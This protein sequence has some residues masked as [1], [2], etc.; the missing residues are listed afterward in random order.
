MAKN[1][2]NVMPTQ[3][4]NKPRTGLEGEQIIDPLVGVKQT[5]RKKIEQKVGVQRLKEQE[6]WYESMKAS[7]YEDAFPPLPDD[8][9]KIVDRYGVV[10]HEATNTA[11]Q[12]EA[13]DKL[14]QKFLD[15][16]T[17]LK[18]IGID[19]QRFKDAGVDPALFP[20]W[21]DKSASQFYTETTNNLVRLST[22]IE[23]LTNIMAQ[24]DYLKHNK[25]PYRQSEY[26]AALEQYNSKLKEFKDGVKLQDQFE[27]VYK[28]TLPTNKEF[29]EDVKSLYALKNNG[30]EEASEQ[31]AK[32]EMSL[33][34]LQNKD[35]IINEQFGG[36]RNAFMQWFQENSTKPEWRRTSPLT[37][38]K[39]RGVD[40]MLQLGDKEREYINMFESP[41]GFIG[42]TGKRL[43]V[44][45]YDGFMSM[46][47]GWSDL[48]GL[49]KGDWKYDSIKS[50]K[51]NYDIENS[52]LDPQIISSALSLLETTNQN[53]FENWGS[54]FFYETSE[55][56]GQMLPFMVSL[57]MTGAMSK[58]GVLSEMTQDLATKFGGAALVKKLFTGDA[59]KLML[60]TY[61]ASSVA[62]I[63]QTMPNYLKPEMDRLAKDKDA[64]WLDY[65]LPFTESLIKSSLEGASET[66]GAHFLGAFTQKFLSKYLFG[67]F[68]L[69]TKPFVKRATTFM[70]GDNIGEV[71]E[72]R[73]N[74]IPDLVQFAFG[75]DYV[76]QDGET[77]DNI[78]DLA[79]DKL[80]QSGTEYLSF[81][82]SSGMQATFL[83]VGS[84]LEWNQNRILE[85]FV[86]NV[87]EKYGLSTE[88]AKQWF[89]ML[90]QNEFVNSK[91]VEERFAKTYRDVFDDTAR[92][93][94]EV[95]ENIQDKEQFIQAQT[96]E[97]LNP[98]NY[99]ITGKSKVIDVISLK[100][101]IDAMLPDSKFTLDNLRGMSQEQLQ[102]VVDDVNN[103]VSK[104]N[105]VLNKIR[106]TV[107]ASTP[108]EE[109]YDQVK[110]L[111]HQLHDDVRSVVDTQQADF[112]Y[113]FDKDGTKMDMNV[114]LYEIGQKTIDPG[115]KQLA[116][117]LAFRIQG[118]TMNFLSDD[119]M[120]KNAKGI[121]IAGSHAFDI[122]SKKHEIFIHTGRNASLMEKTI[123]EEVVHR[124][125][126]QEIVENT[127]G[128]FTKSVENLF[129]TAVKGM[130]KPQ[131][132]QY[133]GNQSQHLH[134]LSEFVAKAFKDT[135]FQAELAKIPYQSSGK[136]VWTQFVK[137][138]YDLL[139]SMGI[140]FGSNSVLAELFTTTTEFIENTSPVKME[141]AMQNA[142]A[143]EA[144]QNIIRAEQEFRATQESVGETE[145][146]LNKLNNDITAEVQNKA[147]VDITPEDVSETFFT[148][149][150]KL[151]KASLS[152]DT[153]GLPPE[154]RTTDKLYD[155][156]N[157]FKIDGMPDFQRFELFDKAFQK[158]FPALHA[159]AQTVEVKSNR[160]YLEE[161]FAQVTNWKPHA[162]ATINMTFGDRGL[163]T[164]KTT[165]KVSGRDSNVYEGVT[166]KSRSTLYR[167]QT[168]D[169][170]AEAL[171]RLGIDANIVEAKVFTKY[172]LGKAGTT[173]VQSTEKATQ[174]MSDGD[175]IPTA[176]FKREL[177]TEGFVSL[178]IMPGTG[179]HL[180]LDLRQGIRVGNVTY[181]FNPKEFANWYLPMNSTFR[182]Y[183]ILNQKNVGGIRYKQELNRR[184]SKNLYGPAF[185]DTPHGLVYKD[186]LMYFTEI[187]KQNPGSTN[188]SDNLYD[189][190]GYAFS[191]EYLQAHGITPTTLQRS[192][193]VGGQLVKEPLQENGQIL[194]PTIGNYLLH[195]D[196]LSEAYKSGLA[197]GVLNSVILDLVHSYIYNRVFMSNVLPSAPNHLTMYKRIVNIIGGE[198]K[199][200]LSRAVVQ[201]LGN[202]TP[203]N[204]LWLNGNQLQVRSVVMQS[205]SVPSEYKEMFGG[206]D[207]ADG[208]S[209]VLPEV[210]DAFNDIN[211]VQASERGAA[212]KP[213]NYNNIEGR[214]NLH[215]K[216][217]FIV[218]PGS[219]LERYMRDNAIGELNMDTALKINNSTKTL[220]TWKEILQR[221]TPTP[222]QM[223][224]HDLMS[225]AH[226][227]NKGKIKS[228]TG[229]IGGAFMATGLAAELTN[230][231]IDVFQEWFLEDVSALKKTIN[232]IVNSPDFVDNVRKAA[233]TSS[234][235]TS[236]TKYISS[237]LSRDF[238]YLA[239]LP[240][241]A[242]FIAQGELTRLLFGAA[243]HRKKGSH[244]VLYPDL[245]PLTGF[246]NIVKN[247][248]PE[249]FSEHGFVSTNYAI[250]DYYTA[251]KRNLK[252]GDK[253]IATANPPSG[254][255]DI[256]ALTVGAIMPKEMGS[257]VIIGNSAQWQGMSGK[258]FDIDAIPV[259][260]VTTETEQK[261]W[262]IVKRVDGD[263]RV[264]EMT[265][266]FKNIY[267]ARQYFIMFNPE[268]FP[269]SNIDADTNALLDLFYRPDLTPEQKEQKRLLENSTTIIHIKPENAPLIELF[270]PNLAFKKLSLHKSEELNNL[271]KLAS[272]AM[273]GRVYNIK[274]FYSLFKEMEK[275]HK[276][277]NIFVTMNT[278]VD[279]NNRRSQYI[280][281]IVAR[282]D[283][284]R[285]VNAG[286]FSTP[287]RHK[288]LIAQ[289]LR[290]ESSE[291]YTVRAQQ[292]HDEIS[293]VLNRLTH[294][295]LDWA[296]NLEI[297]Q[298]MTG[299]GIDENVLFAK[300]YDGA[301]PEVIRA[302]MRETFMP[303]RK[304]MQKVDSEEAF[305]STTYVTDLQDAQEV[306][307][308]SPFRDTI[309]FRSIVDLADINISKIV[310][311]TDQYEEINSQ[312]AKEFIGEDISTPQGYTNAENIWKSMSAPLKKA[313]RLAT[314]YHQLSGNSDQ[315]TL[316]DELANLSPKQ[317]L[318]FIVRIFD[319]GAY[320]INK[321]D[322]K[323]W[324][325]SDS[326]GR[327]SII[328]GLV[329]EF[330]GQTPIFSYFTYDSSRTGEK[331]VKEEGYSG[332][333]T[334]ST[335][336]ALP[337]GSMTIGDKI[338]A[339]LTRPTTPNSPSLAR[340]LFAESISI[341]D[342]SRLKTMSQNRMEE[343][344]NNLLTSEHF[345]S[346]T[347]ENKILFCASLFGW[348]TPNVNL[349]I[350]QP[351]KRKDTLI[352][353]QT[354]Y[355]K[356]PIAPAYYLNQ[357][358]S[359]PVVL[360][361]L[362]QY[363]L[364]ANTIVKNVIEQE[365]DNE[366]VNPDG[367]VF[368][369]VLFPI[370]TY[371]LKKAGKKFRKWWK[372]VA[373]N[374][375][376]S[377][378]QIV[379]KI[380]TNT[381]YANLF[382]PEQ[383]MMYWN[384]THR[385][386]PITVDE[387]A[388]EHK[389]EYVEM[390]ME[391][392]VQAKIVQNKFLK[393][394]TP[395][396][397]DIQKEM[398]TV[399]NE[400]MTKVGKSEPWLFS[401]MMSRKLPTKALIDIY[402]HKNKLFRSGDIVAEYIVDGRTHSVYAFEVGLHFDYVGGRVDR[403]ISLSGAM[404]K[405][406]I[407]TQVDRHFANQEDEFKQTVDG[408]IDAMVG[409][410]TGLTN[411]D[412]LNVFSDLGSWTRSFDIAEG[413]DKTF[414]L[415]GIKVNKTGVIEYNGIEY[416]V[417]I[418]KEDAVNYNATKDNSLI[419][420][421][422][423]KHQYDYAK[424]M[425]LAKAILMSRQMY[426]EQPANVVDKYLQEIALRETM[427]ALVYRYVYDG[428]LHAKLLTQRNDFAKM[429]TIAASMSTAN[430]IKLVATTKIKEAMD[431]VDILLQEMSA[432]KQDFVKARATGKGAKFYMPH[433]H[434]N[435]EAVEKQLVIKY[436][437][438]FK[439][440]KKSFTQKDVDK[441]VRAEL[442]KHIKQM[443]FLAGS[444]TQ[445]TPRIDLPGYMKT[446]MATDATINGLNASFRS[447]TLGIY[448][449]ITRNLMDDESTFM[450]HMS[451]RMSAIVQ[452]S[453]NFAE[454]T[455][456]EKLSVGQFVTFITPRLG[457]DFITGDQ[458][459][460][461]GADNI[462]EWHTTSG[463]IVEASDNSFK[464][465]MISA[466][467]P[468]GF[469]FAVFDKRHTRD[470]RV[471]KGVNV[472]KK[473][474]FLWYKI[475]RSS[476]K[477]AMVNED[478]TEL[479]TFKLKA[480]G[481]A[482]LSG[483]PTYAMTNLFGGHIQNW[484]YFGKKD[485]KRHKNEFLKLLD[486]VESGTL[487]TSDE[488]LRKY[489][490]IIIDNATAFLG[491][492]NSVMG[493]FGGVITSVKA[494]QHQT[495]EFVQYTEKLQKQKNDYEDKL[496][497]AIKEYR[498][499]NKPDPTLIKNV[500]QI[501]QRFNNWWSEWHLYNFPGGLF[502]RSGFLK[503]AEW[504][505]P[506]ETEKHLR[507]R[508]AVT[509][510][511]VMQE[512]FDQSVL[513]T[514]DTAKKRLMLGM[515]DHA[516]GS[517]QYYYNPGL[518][519][520]SLAST[521]VGRNYS[522]YDHYS[523]S[524][525]IQY[526][527]R[528][529]NSL[530]QIKDFGFVNSVVLPVIR[531]FKKGDKMIYVARIKLAGHGAYTDIELPSY[532][533]ATRFMRMTAFAWVTWLFK[534]AKYAFMK[535]LKWGTFG[536]VS[537]LLMFFVGDRL[538][539]S[540]QLGIVESFMNYIMHLLS[541]YMQFPEGD[542]DD[543]TW[544]EQ[545]TKDFLRHMTT[546]TEDQHA[547]KILEKDEYISYE[548]I[549]NSYERELLN[550]LAL[551]MYPTGV[552]ESQL[553]EIGASMLLTSFAPD[554]VREIVWNQSKTYM[555]LI[556]STLELS[557]L[558]DRDVFKYF[559]ID[560]IGYDPVQSARMLNARLNQEYAEL[561]KK[562][563]IKR[564]QVEEE[565]FKALEE[566]RKQRKIA[567]YETVKQFYKN[568]P[569]N[570]QLENLYHELGEDVTKLR[571]KVPTY[572]E[573]EK[574]EMFKTGDHD[575][576]FMADPKGFFVRMMEKEFGVKV[577][578]MDQQLSDT[579]KQIMH[580]MYNASKDKD[581]F[582][583]MMMAAAIHAP[584]EFETILPASPFKT[585][586]LRKLREAG[587]KY[588]EGSEQKHT[589]F[590][591]IS[592]MF[593]EEK[594]VE[595]FGNKY[596][597]FIQL[598]STNQKDTIK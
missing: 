508:T 316:L 558:F 371:L 580:D 591:D 482:L 35:K 66:A 449:H 380:L 145:T 233:E 553:I 38:K 460:I 385:D 157:Q 48:M 305:T 184:N 45:A 475:F 583:E 32:T 459:Y 105:A 555:P 1:E 164:E 384:A 114:V 369:S 564:T 320:K 346:Q 252:P 417:A 447:R 451:H 567:S 592:K 229:G 548:T 170:V 523:M 335:L 390:F 71:F 562:G 166:G 241:V 597:Q 213:K 29:V 55:L 300:M 126:A 287:D 282:D 312:L 436:T 598:D 330:E 402:S 47:F 549:H 235:Q 266:A 265:E 290:Y 147:D 31:I 231:E 301:P 116:N 302:M 214:E 259:V 396:A 22:D 220:T 206:A 144:K 489:F 355:E 15:F 237:V 394:G 506:L 273:I 182:Y 485:F 96:V 418:T 546:G 201:K 538:G 267:L 2:G 85:Q 138:V 404:I 443:T 483:K 481:L 7:K 532:V 286:V 222:S 438:Q 373:S 181:K 21:G 409:N 519:L 499:A 46:V 125:T 243:S 60:K 596:G 395:T 26:D 41:L 121:P 215:K 429:L 119:K 456:M 541:P 84:G 186:A 594:Y 498:A 304:M 531:P 337:Y 89:S 276:G 367:I 242:N 23:N 374:T 107:N 425:E 466:T 585:Q 76:N 360:E 270:G 593:M 462:I 3:L 440:D 79:K 415:N 209:F 467:D 526:F 309:L 109:L 39:V 458:I 595:E 139:G 317:Y 63:W 357:A 375:E 303:V 322:K 331:R 421:L 378:D 584:E 295:V 372:D 18:N 298:F 250:V 68:D 345:A 551:P 104:R 308:K 227:Q 566:F 202:N 279:K 333:S 141:K 218:P 379:D 376:L 405:H 101:S 392:L 87:G 151:Y 249:T 254:I 487:Q 40:A 590:K 424:L 348:L 364:K 315:L 328:D 465:K 358:A 342:N 354:T 406:Y 168:Y 573:W 478:I 503:T 382:S 223:F 448:G 207:P 160:T 127:N 51:L 518:Y 412:D 441:A 92:S 416:K 253:L 435:M 530:H 522:L 359:D 95:T 477:A 272:Q 576:L 269:A 136:S 493:K 431:H 581:D 368:M 9:Q 255:Q 156:V 210:Q 256:R 50:A 513:S 433:L 90:Q 248:L 500:F 408:V 211:G 291:N 521:P 285:E 307:L 571:N 391:D 203:A 224:I 120:P 492:V 17:P 14:G 323:I 178:M 575:K 339:T 495:P 347:E 155:F 565:R 563:R 486:S 244:M 271:S 117:A 251:K 62:G 470:I 42:T 454:V 476:N 70:I 387:V 113:S 332:F 131:L 437:N 296:S 455:P 410:H 230:A 507:T 484:A 313:G 204:P 370:P 472:Q 446:P 365:T 91:P 327:A 361:F 525:L 537:S 574:D 194:E 570:E 502:V 318:D 37:D 366:N 547:F 587:M 258:D 490:D 516:I 540:M 491:N 479:A 278:Y 13:V 239:K 19:P 283:K 24:V 560:P 185:A 247:A 321:T 292:E 137:A 510:A 471:L 314:V 268:L 299:N 501:A 572:E 25:L 69:F 343:F 236:L 338:F 123:I 58:M 169:I 122:G 216:A 129:H 344:L 190:F 33:W 143:T 134:A 527:K 362:E 72:E 154:L 212:S 158:R 106:E 407:E 103:A 238:P 356:N 112:A 43:A 453:D 94:A 497:T 159:V 397:F 234:Y 568:Y 539:E 30:T 188:L 398:F 480:H 262:D 16:H 542:D 187:E 559:G 78:T 27:T 514:N 240:G 420:N 97:R 192:Y 422:A 517:T 198:K 352:G 8:I 20:I 284:G 64:T 83:N 179:T 319:E 152:T 77:I 426:V 473:T 414:L 133:I 528:I 189:T 140:K 124:F 275:R 280:N 176:R 65:V 577:H 199:S 439:A 329:V 544:Y 363:K 536:A 579:G 294:L 98:S 428:F 142:I 419:P 353:A 509:I 148:L 5:A 183:N 174:F 102:T 4:D 88:S 81:M 586:L 36:D 464:L 505:N 554:N 351:I 556:H 28:G 413:T 520:S 383:V 177:M 67:N 452:G 297:L 167:Q 172:K 110:E 86:T 524:L 557:K 61:G 442:R 44:G 543:K 334:L 195:F 130:G 54:E 388:E 289:G 10:E 474:A 228:D 341:V 311:S 450:R 403:P 146:E 75:K 56:T 221:K 175:Q 389:K 463:E 274:M 381:D 535:T 205:G 153:K 534:T 208:A 511:A 512:I 401:N 434:E 430:S 193:R 6:Q 552:G 226:I 111:D 11:L 245:G 277:F 488:N 349:T 163:I 445:N 171:V 494:G 306:G 377:K 197:A 219:V 533:E 99:T 561:N 149:Q 550:K 132:Q 393:K 589:E 588:M 257:N 118:Q 232:A 310:L 336:L 34:A 53:K 288:A 411:I 545:F 400:A 100:Q 399:L 161:L 200:F 432:N 423:K 457:T 427:T 150:D 582:V 281:R 82:F 469:E 261:V 73:I 74:D 162:I 350:A 173:T 529:Q 57:G 128:E 515:I 340:K 326:T 444:Q 461:R 196:S 324:I 108:I 263:R 180:L 496:L 325:G 246:K 504:I 293:M 569:S 225:D 191:K 165:V 49:T 80:V 468:T 264:K 12:L 52:G 59:L 578:Q 260:K 115:V 93:V 386:N 217:R 135:K